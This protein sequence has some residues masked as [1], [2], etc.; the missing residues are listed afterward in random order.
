MKFLLPIVTVLAHIATAVIVLALAGFI[1]LFGVYAVA[2]TG[3]S[4]D[5]RTLISLGWGMLVG[6]AVLKGFPMA[7]A[8]TSHLLDR[9]EY[10]PKRLNNPGR[11]HFEPRK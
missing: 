6:C 10:T 8:L 7:H 1:L 4:P 2:N 5:L 3:A 9:T 11:L